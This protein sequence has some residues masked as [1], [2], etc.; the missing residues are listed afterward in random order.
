[1]GRI[2][3]RTFLA[4]VGGIEYA[5]GADLQLQ[6]SIVGVF[7]HHA[8]AVG[9]DP[10]IVFVIDGATVRGR[11]HHVP[12]APRL[13]HIAFPIEY[14]DRRRLYAGFPF[15]VRDV[16][17]INNQHVVAVIHVYARQLPG[18]PSFRQRFR[19]PR[20]DFKARCGGLRR[21]WHN[22]ADYSGRCRRRITGSH[23]TSLFVDSELCL[24]NTQGTT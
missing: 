16:A 1:M 18:D 3:T 2:R 20:I 14:H 12:L 17:A 15:F 9:G 23:M 19:P 7:L 8:V 11:W 4:A 22:G 10:H 13:N 21:V 6:L 5:L 24:G